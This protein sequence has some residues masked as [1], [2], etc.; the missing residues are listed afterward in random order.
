M[1]GHREERI[2]RRAYEIWEQ[3]GR[4]GNP[5]DHWLRAE[6]ELREPSEDTGG[7]AAEAVLPDEAV[8][9]ADAAIRQ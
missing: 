5:D 9:A 7:I 8:A 1:D 4:A 6:R 2:R 3:E